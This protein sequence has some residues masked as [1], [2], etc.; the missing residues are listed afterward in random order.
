M[1]DTREVRRGRCGATHGG[2]PIGLVRIPGVVATQRVLNETTCGYAVADYKQL[3]Q[4]G[5]DLGSLE[6]GREGQSLGLDIAHKVVHKE[7]GRDRHNAEA[8]ENGEQDDGS[9]LFADANPHLD[10][11]MSRP[12]SR[13]G[14]S[15]TL[16]RSNEVLLVIETLY[17]RTRA[18]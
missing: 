5:G 15:A 11:N 3:V 13:G 4:D 1:K 16:E 14:R 18:A 6:R 17:F 7:P 10:D 9:K 12:V 2:I 8:D